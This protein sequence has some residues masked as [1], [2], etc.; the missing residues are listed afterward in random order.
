MLVVNFARFGVWCSRLLL[1]LLMFT[2]HVISCFLLRQMEYDADSYE[3]KLAGSEAFEST[4]KRMAVLNAAHDDAGGNAVL[5]FAGQDTL[6]FSGV[7]AATLQQHA[8]DFLLA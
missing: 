5:S 6:T 4:A 7:H 1:K 3:I 2:G 8:G